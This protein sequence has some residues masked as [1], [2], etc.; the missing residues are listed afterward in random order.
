MNKDKYITLKLNEYALNLIKLNRRSISSDLWEYIHGLLT[1]KQVL[2][3]NNSILS[4]MQKFSK[5]TSTY[6]EGRVGFP[7]RGIR[8]VI[9]DDKFLDEYRRDLGGGVFDSTEWALCIEKLYLNDKEGYQKLVD[10]TSLL[11]INNTKKA[12]KESPFYRN[13]KQ[14]SKAFELDEFEVE[15]VAFFYLLDIDDSLSTLTR[16]K[17]FQLD[18]IVKSTTILGKIFGVNQ[19]EMK[20]YLSRKSRLISAG[21]FEVGYDDINLSNFVKFYLSGIVVNS[22][23]DNFFT[24]IESDTILELN[25]HFIAPKNI[26]TICNLIRM[27]KGAHILL[28]GSPGTGKTEFSKSIAKFLNK[29]I[30]FINQADED[31]KEDFSHRKSAIVAARNILSK[32][33][34]I[35]V[36]ECDSI[37]N[38]K[39]QFSLFF[40]IDDSKDTK[41]W[42]NNLLDNSSHTIIWITNTVENIDSSTRRRFSYSQEF[43]D[44]SKKQREKVWRT[45][46]D[47]NDID[48]INDEDVAYFS[49][50]YHINSGGIS[51]AVR[52]L[53]KMKG[54]TLRDDRLSILEN[55]LNQHEGFVFQNK[56]RM[57]DIDPAYNINVLNTSSSIGLLLEKMKKFTNY[58]RGGD[59]RLIQNFNILLYGPSGTGKTESVKYLAEELGLDLVVK[60]LSDIKSKWYGETL[61]NIS[62]IFHDASNSSKILFL[63]EADSF[64]VDRMRSTNNSHIEETNEIL[65]QME[66]YRGILICSTNLF[67]NMDQA[68]LRRFT[69]KIS[70]DYLSNEGKKVLFSKYFKEYMKNNDLNFLTDKFDEI[71]YLTPGDFKVVKQKFFFNDNVNV[72]EILSELAYESSLKKINTRK[73]GL[74]KV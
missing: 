15:I 21:L 60:R 43:K 64:F 71:K 65:N 17:Y 45:V 10:Q 26:E 30:Y 28:Y 23:A 38:I 32:D 72:G 74:K 9:L 7:K 52:D 67:E 42:L 16:S 56:A 37:L 50:K 39:K 47:Q 54:V 11:L 6:R 48:F 40:D 66:N 33:S 18:K 5:Q 31:D 61:K 20:R 49:T 62:S 4:E 44:L 13:L 3:L 70:F 35:V 57:I 27:E 1:K 41:S 19:Y 34:I 58:S 51:L 14:I 63:D 69:Y 68:V 73:V 36:D 2:R 53:L 8:E 22:I 25:A 55:I 12:Q 59:N 24:K 29:D 46:I